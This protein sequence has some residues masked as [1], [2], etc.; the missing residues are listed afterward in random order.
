M[1]PVMAQVMITF[2]VRRLAIA[3]P[4]GRSGEMRLEMARHL[5]PQFGLRIRRPVLKSTPR[6]EAQPFFSNKLVEIWRRFSC[7]IERRQYVAVN[8]TGQT[9]PNHTGVLDRAKH[10]KPRPEARFDDLIHRLCVA[11]PRSDQGDRLAP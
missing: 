4:P 9:D 6:L 7:P 1:P 2:S 5:C 8:R 3:L 10:P 11:H